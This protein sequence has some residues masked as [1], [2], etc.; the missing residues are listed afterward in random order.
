MA[1]NPFENMLKQLETAQEISPVDKNIYEILKNPQRILIASIPVEMDNGEVKVFTAYRVQHNDTRGP[2]KGGIRYHPNVSLDE[3]KALA[4]WMTW[5]CATVDIPF[6][7][8]KGGVICNPREMSQDEI[9]R[10]SRGYVRAFFKFLGEDTDV[11]APD[12]YTNAQVMAWMLDEYNKLAG[13]SVPAFITGKPIE[14]GGSEGR[15]TATAQGGA[16]VIREAIKHKQ[17]D[18]TAATAAIQGYGNAGYNAAKLLYGMGFTIVA[19]SDSRGGAYNE[20]G[21]D[22]DEVF[23]HKK[24]TGS[25]VGFPNEEITNEQLLELNVDVLVPAALE[26]AISENNA[27]NIKA[28]VVAELANGPVTPEADKILY[29]KGVF[30]CPDILT[31]A[32]GVTVSYFEWVQ[33]K[34][35]AH[36]TE[37]E[38]FKKL[39]GIMTKAFNDVLKTSL[40]KK[41]DMRTAA[42]ILAMHRVAD[43]TKLSGY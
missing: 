10:L 25:V 2:T 31:N 30:V 36:W 40:E 21:M 9:E 8:G 6:G 13:K 15:G 43:A 4:G 38:V 20:N 3:V 34:S 16:Y 17:I 18:P 12:V 5:K 23:K 32:G 35:Q 26:S 39:D 14:L 11:P 24:E 33:N 28:K 29:E 27:A 22:P 37:E 42:F 41:V 19:V 1:E 7:G